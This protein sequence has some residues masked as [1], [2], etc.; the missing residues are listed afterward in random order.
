MMHLIYE[1]ASITVVN[2]SGRSANSGIPGISSPRY[3]RIPETFE[4][5]VFARHHQS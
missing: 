2:V 1:C 4:D 3:T 5:T